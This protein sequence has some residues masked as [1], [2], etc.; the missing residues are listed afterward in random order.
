MRSDSPAQPCT[1]DEPGNQFTLGLRLHGQSAK[2][3][4]D[5]PIGQKPVLR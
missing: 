2:G 3:C 5:D 4:S 1:N